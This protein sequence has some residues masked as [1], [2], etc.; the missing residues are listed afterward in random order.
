M[1]LFPYAEVKPNSNVAIYGAGD[2]GRDYVR[3][4]RANDFCKIVF[5]ADKTATATPAYLFKGIDVCAPDA[6]AERSDY[7]YVVVATVRETYQKEMAARLAA[8]GVA[9]SKIVTKTAALDASSGEKTY[10]Q[11]GED[12]I[13]YNALQHMG[14]FR[15]GKTPSY[16]DVGAHHPY[17]ISNTA[18]FYELGCRGVNIEADPELIEAFYEERPDDVNLCFGVGSEPGTLPFYINEVS[19][20]NTF[21]KENVAY[22]EWLYEKDTGK[23]EKF[24][25]QKVLEIPVRTLQSVIDEYCGGIWPDYMSIDIEGM[26]YD[27]LRVCDLTNGPAILAVEV[28]FD[29]D[30]FI[31]MMREKGYFPYLWYRENILFVKD[32][33]ETMVHAHEERSK[34]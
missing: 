12:R 7:D 13:I 24:N 29:G 31:E 2:V 6:F 30:L 21:R 10:S 17:H 22:N 9:A 4:L 28:N 5:V 33:Y 14:F 3:Q 1:Y 11:H 20:L 15:D 26:E 27:S 8:L 16:I 32:E 25:V 19:G 18:L 23:Q 34:I